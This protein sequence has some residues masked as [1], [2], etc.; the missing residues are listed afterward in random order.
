MRAIKEN[1]AP[2]TAVYSM[3]AYYSMPGILFRMSSFAADLLHART[4][5]EIDAICK[6]YSF[7]HPAHSPCADPNR[8]VSR[9]FPWRFHKTDPFVP[10]YSSWLLERMHTISAILQMYTV[11]LPIARGKTKNPK[12][13]DL[14]DMLYYAYKTHQQM[15]LEAHRNNDWIPREDIRERRIKSALRSLP[16]FPLI[17]LFEGFQQK[18]GYELQRCYGHDFKQMRRRGENSPP[19]SQYHYWQNPSAIKEVK[20]R[21]WKYTYD[22]PAEY[23]SYIFKWQA[24]DLAEVYLDIL[25]RYIEHGLGEVNL[26]LDSKT[27]TAKLVTSGGLESALNLWLFT[28]IQ[29]QM[30][31][32]ICKMCGNLFVPG[33]QKGKKYCDLHEKHE[34]NYYNKT[35]GKLTH[36]LDSNISE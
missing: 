1:K 29:A 24:Q 35:I 21:I 30:G 18:D 33:A 5:V 25:D 12:T 19:K 14:F 11:C 26:Q 27:G 4:E 32:K 15:A 2:D 6:R 9:Q 3:E 8:L 17:E 20:D 13:T 31:Y 36:S 7:Q 22:H 34:I 23:D 28:Q 10:S 16:K